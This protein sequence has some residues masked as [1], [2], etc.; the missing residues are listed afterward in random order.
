MLREVVRRLL[1]VKRRDH[2][3]MADIPAIARYVEPGANGHGHGPESEI[4]A[5]TND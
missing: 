5:L 1:A 3:E 2:K 4:D